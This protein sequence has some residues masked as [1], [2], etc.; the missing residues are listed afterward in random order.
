MSSLNREGNNTILN[1]RKRGILKTCLQ[2]FGQCVQI[3]TSMIANIVIYL[4]RKC[5][6]KYPFAV[7]YGENSALFH[8][9]DR[10]FTFK[11]RHTLET[12]NFM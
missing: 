2:W 9:F 5:L 4:N 7:I 8:Q 11:S 12:V 10:L 6:Q 3:K 1:Y